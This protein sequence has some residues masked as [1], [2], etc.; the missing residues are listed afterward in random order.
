MPLS[1]TALKP[2]WWISEVHTY[3]WFQKRWSNSC[4]VWMPLNCT[5]MIRSW[6]M[7]NQIWSP[8]TSQARLIISCHKFQGQSSIKYVF[9]SDCSSLWLISPI[10]PAKY[11]YL[12]AHCL[13]LRESEEQ[14]FGQQMQSKSQEPPAVSACGPAQNSQKSPL[15]SGRKRNGEKAIAT[16]L[17]H[18]TRLPE[19]KK[20]TNPIYSKDNII[21]LEYSIGCHKHILLNPSLIRG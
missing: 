17:T 7:Q 20:K 13:F 16:V 12:S 15:P 11:F 9:W 14:L 4:E 10:W 8:Q 2:T 6:N 3:I 18:S 21:S 19:K 5:D 1:R